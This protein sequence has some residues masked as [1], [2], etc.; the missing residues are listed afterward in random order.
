MNGKTNPD[1]R[2]VVPNTNR[3]LFTFRDGDHLV[4]VSANYR[5]YREHAVVSQHSDFGF[6]ITR[7]HVADFGDC[8]GDFTRL[9]DARRTEHSACNAFRRVRGATNGEHSA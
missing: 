6:E 8:I 3:D 9:D 5:R 7:Y 2:F 1:W 4:V